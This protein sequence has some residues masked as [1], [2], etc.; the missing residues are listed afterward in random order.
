MHD[1][2]FNFRT[3]VRCRVGSSEMLGVHIL[4][5]GSLAL[6]FELLFAAA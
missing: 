5:A 2:P 6:C 3:I 4:R 1:H